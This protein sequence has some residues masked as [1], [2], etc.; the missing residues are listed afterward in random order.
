M[1]KRIR[2]KR[3]LSKVT[4]EE[5]WD[6]DITIAKFILPRLYKF[7]EYNINSHPGYFNSI[8]EWHDIIDKIIWSFEYILKDQFMY[9]DKETYDKNEERYKEGMNLFAEYL[10]SLWD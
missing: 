3:G 2:K 5:L 7:K 4:K 9:R 1:N 6:L 10:R 8:E